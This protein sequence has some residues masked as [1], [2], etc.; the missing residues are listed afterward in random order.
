MLGSI[1]LDWRVIDGWILTG[2]D[3]TMLV[4]T[5]AHFEPTKPP[6]APGTARYFGESFRICLAACL[7]TLLFSL[8]H[9]L[10]LSSHPAV[11]VKSEFL[12]HL[13]PWGH[14]VF[15]LP[16]SAAFHWETNTAKHL[17]VEQ[18]P[19]P[20]TT[21]PWKGFQRWGNC[22]SFTIQMDLKKHLGDFVT[23]FDVGPGMTLHQWHTGRHVTNVTSALALTCSAQVCRASPQRS[24]AGTWLLSVSLDRALPEGFTFLPLIGTVAVTVAEDCSAQVGSRPGF[25]RSPAVA[26]TTELCASQLGANK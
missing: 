25:Y 9:F 17:P 18:S 1:R 16:L 19:L 10:H 11:P 4:S 3:R 12:H 26:G 6:S 24:V 20:N 23:T 2:D 15:Q 14:R 13:H 21:T 22:L 5:Q 8:P 7:V